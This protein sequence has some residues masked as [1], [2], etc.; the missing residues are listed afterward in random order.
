MDDGTAAIGGGTAAATRVC[1]QPAPR[2]VAGGRGAGVAGGGG[3][4]AFSGL[5][6]NKIAP[7][8]GTG[9]FPRLG[10]FTFR[11]LSA[12]VLPCHGRS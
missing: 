10:T 9:W 3:P 4:A 8:H 6:L 2:L 1:L 5:G 7:E 12:A 11:L